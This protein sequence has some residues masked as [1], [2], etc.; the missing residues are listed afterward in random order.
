[1]LEVVAAADDDP[2]NFDQRSSRIS[3]A[4]KPMEPLRTL[5]VAPGLVVVP[6]S[7]RPILAS[8]HVTHMTWHVVLAVQEISYEN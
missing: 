3:A 8:G 5:S 7:F 6:D 4:D 1:M 2:K